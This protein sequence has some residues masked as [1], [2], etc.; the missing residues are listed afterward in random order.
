M[1]SVMNPK[2]VPYSLDPKAVYNWYKLIPN[3]TWWYKK[4]QGLT[5]F[6]TFQQDGGHQPHIVEI[7]LRCAGYKTLGRII[8]ISAICR[9]RTSK[10]VIY[11]MSLIPGTDR[12][13]A[14]CLNVYSHYMNRVFLF[15]IL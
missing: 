11:R 3:S 1:M 15:R 9:H 5:L 2:M 8:D 12:L 7:H 14:V 10:G 4:R 13:F 6:M